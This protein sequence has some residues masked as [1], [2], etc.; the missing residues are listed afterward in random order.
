MGRDGRRA[1][2]PC[3]RPARL[4]LFPL[5]ELSLNIAVL[6]D[7]EFVDDGKTV[8]TRQ[9]LRCCLV[10]NRSPIVHRRTTA[11]ESPDPLAAPR[12]H[13][14]VRGHEDAL[15]LAV[16]TAIGL[17]DGPV[18]SH[19]CTVKAGDLATS[20]ERRFHLRGPIG[21]QYPHSS[22]L[23]GFLTEDLA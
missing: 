3:Q 20:L 15:P 11:C 17:H 23:A 21:R 2:L 8:Q 12:G 18:R 1:L 6:I 9:L 22:E 19:I 16:E 14:A 5:P 13:P 7:V 10:V 4:P